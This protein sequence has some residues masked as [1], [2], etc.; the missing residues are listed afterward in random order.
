ML[1]TQY[2]CRNSDFLQKSESQLNS[3]LTDLS[4]EISLLNTKYNALKLYRLKIYGDGVNLL[5]N[6]GESVYNFRFV[7]ANSNTVG[8]GMFG[9]IIPGS[10]TIP[11]IS[12]RFNGNTIVYYGSAELSV[13][14]NTK[15]S[16][17]RQFRFHGSDDPSTGTGSGSVSQ[18][19][20][21][22]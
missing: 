2:L 12:T 10:T 22:R 18:I 6:I 20:L 8:Y 16:I 17:S 9:A 11:L 1:Q 4:G 7:V 3:N 14:N 21:V 13:S 19:W 15:I 5:N